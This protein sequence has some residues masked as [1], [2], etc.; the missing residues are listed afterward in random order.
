MED[1]KDYTFKEIAE[2]AR[3]LVS[4]KVAYLAKELGFNV[5][6]N[7][8]YETLSDGTV[9]TSDVN[10]Y[11]WNSPI[12]KSTYAAPTQEVLHKWL[13]EIKGITI[14]IKPHYCNIHEWT[15]DIYASDMYITDC[16]VI[17]S[18]TVYKTYEDAYNAGLYRTLEFIRDTKLRTELRTVV[19]YDLFGDPIYEDDNHLLT[20]KYNESKRCGYL[21]MDL[22]EKM[23][24]RADYKFSYNDYL[25]YKKT[26]RVFGVITKKT[27]NHLFQSNKIK[28]GNKTVPDGRLLKTFLFLHIECKPNEL[29][30]NK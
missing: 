16:R 25:E 27:Y 26:H 1:K 3:T 19:A 5:P 30:I 4:P 12:Y 9:Y 24:E 7:I 17:S 18:D 23:N 21:V 15:Y 29:N 2:I 6:T 20:I 10:Y 8:I 14:C 13:R 11:N 22:R 28:V